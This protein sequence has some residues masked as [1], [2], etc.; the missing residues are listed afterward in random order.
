[1][2]YIEHKEITNYINSL[3]GDNKSINTL[4]NYRVDL[5]AYERWAI[6]QGI[7][8]LNVNL[9]ILNAYKVFLKHLVMSNGKGYAERTLAKKT[10]TVREFYSYLK[11]NGVIN[12]NPAEYLTVPSI[13]SNERPI[14]ISLEESLRLIKSTHG[15][16]H[17]IRDKAILTI[18]LTVG[19]RV[20]E[21]VDIN[22]EDIKDKTLTVHGKGNKV[23]Y[24]YLNELCM[25]VIGKQ[26]KYNQY[27]CGD[28]L[29]VSQHGNRMS[30]Q[31]VQLLVKKYVKIAKIKQNISPHKLRHTAATLMMATGKIDIRTI[32]EIL[33]H[34]SIATTQK[35]THV[36][37]EQLQKA[38]RI[39]EDLLTT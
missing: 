4:T 29:F 33:G 11:R 1:M 2:E 30:T 34:S 13:I 6:E 7:D 26:I 18:L 38:S 8:I 32:Q 22:K 23:R 20:S 15:E 12:D 19:L 21:L 14:Y 25:A 31:T 24:I 39:M 10:T 28:A 36:L 16:F 37:D 27:M 5:K 9:Q 3:D 35:Y 17:E